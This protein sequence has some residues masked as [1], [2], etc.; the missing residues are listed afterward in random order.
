MPRVRTIAVTLILLSGVLNTSPEKARATGLFADAVA[1]AGF[2]CARNESAARARLIVV[3][4]ERT[5]GSLVVFNAS[6]MVRRFLLLDLEQ[7][8]VTASVGGESVESD[9]G[10]T[11]IRARFRLFGRSGKQLSLL[12]NVGTGTGSSSVF[13]FS[14]ESLEVAASIGWVDSLGAFSYW[15]LVGAETVRRRPAELDGDPEIADFSRV[16]VGAAWQ[17]RAFSLR[18]GVSVLR[19]SQT[20]VRDLAFGELAWDYRTHFR[21]YSALQIEGGRSDERISNG[22]IHLGMS[23]FL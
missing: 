19:F 23:V 15:G 22:S 6:F 14:S 4:A 21:F 13:P 1:D 8:F 3:E 5:D 11:R 18:A 17:I 7:P 16:N 20:T 9:F 2:L 12:F 10:D